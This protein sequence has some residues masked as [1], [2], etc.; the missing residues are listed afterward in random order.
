IFIGEILLGIKSFLLLHDL[1]QTGIAHNYRIQRGI[2]I[3]FEV[4]LLQERKTLSRSNGYIAFRRLKLTGQNLQER[5]FS[6]SVRTDQAV[7]VS[8]S[9]F[10]VYFFEKSFLSDSQCYV[11]GCNHFLY[12]LFLL[13]VRLLLTILHSIIEK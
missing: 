6:R 9:K 5:R 1:I 2:R 8:F 4:V 12:L 3:I 10:D 7:A 13:L 11:V